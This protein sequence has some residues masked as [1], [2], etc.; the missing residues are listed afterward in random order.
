MADQENNKYNYISPILEYRISKV[1]LRDDDILHIMIKENEV[2]NA[3]DFMD[4]FEAAGKIG[5]GKRFRNLV[6]IGNHTLPD[7]EARQLSTSKEGSIYKIA[8]AFVIRT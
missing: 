7:T 2:F 5:N 1:A 4:L 8:D 6:S 3:R